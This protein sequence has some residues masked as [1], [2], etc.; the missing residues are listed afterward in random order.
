MTNTW[1]KKRKKETFDD[2][3]R[4]I[5]GDHS[6]NDDEDYIK[7]RISKVDFDG[8][9]G[10]NNI[11]E[12]TEL[13]DIH[14]KLCNYETMKWNEIAHD[15]SHSIPIKRIVPE[16]Q[17]RLS[18]LKY[19]DIEKLF[20]FRIAWKQRVWAIR[21]RQDA[22]LLWWDPNHEISVGRT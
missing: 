15:K 21:I 18:E 7:F 22:F 6:K 10:W 14:S 12:K 16:A 1:K 9:W 20:S 13:R 17:K 19:D 4:A 11:S 2:I 3:R 5:S 8:K